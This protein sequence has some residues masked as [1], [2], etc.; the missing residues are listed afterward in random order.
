M[1]PSCPTC[2]TPDGRLAAFFDPP[3]PRTVFDDSEIDQVA[4]LLEQCEHFASKYPHTYTLFRPIGHLDH[5]E[6]VVGVGFSDQ[7]FPVDVRKL[8]SFLDPNVE[9]AVTHQQGIIL[10]K[11][12]GLESGSHRHFEFGEP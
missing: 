7:L 12:F 4:F 8:P 9:A 6:E 1:A 11:A 10:T 2:D 3:T 5:L